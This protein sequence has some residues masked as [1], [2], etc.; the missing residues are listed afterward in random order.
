MAAFC[1]SFD[2]G[3]RSHIEKR[4]QAHLGWHFLASSPRCSHAFAISSSARYIDGFRGSSGVVVR[5][6]VAPK[7]G[8]QSPSR[9]P[10]MGLQLAGEREGKAPRERQVNREQGNSTVERDGWRVCPFQGYPLLGVCGLGLQCGRCLRS[11]LLF[12]RPSVAFHPSSVH[13]SQMVS[14]REM[15]RL[16]KVFG[17]SR[18]RTHPSDDSRGKFS[19]GWFVDGLTEEEEAAFLGP[20]GSW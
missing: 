14:N 7:S 5:L 11:G 3:D 18:Q 20:G 9:G 8:F 19:A 2:D 1:C 15:E 4:D 12:R 6:T 10:Q 16:G 17:S 13:R